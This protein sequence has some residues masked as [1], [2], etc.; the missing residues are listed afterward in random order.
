MPNR[1]LVILIIASAL[2]M[3]NL[4]STVLTT[5]L[6]AIA[7]DFGEDPIRLK[8]ALTSYLIGLAVFIPASGWLA[9]RFGARNV[10]STA[11]LVFIT[12]SILC[13]L[14]QSIGHIVVARVIQ[15]LG[16]A[17]MVPVGRLVVLR[18]VP[19]SEMVDAMAW[20]AIPAL[21]GPVL[22]PPLG[23]F[24][25][26]YFSWQWIFWINVP[27]G[28]V[29]LVLARI[30]VP[31]IREEARPRFDIVGFL[32]SGLGLSAIVSGSTTMG[33]DVIPLPW[34]AA[35]LAVG[36]ILIAAYVRHSRRVAAPILDLSLFAVP[37]YRAAVLGGMLFRIGIG[38]SPFLLPL[39]LQIGFGLTPFQS[40]MITF[41][42]ALGAIGMKLCASRLVRHFGFR[43]ILVLNAL[44][45][46]AFVAV[47]AAFS[48]ATPFALIVAILLVGGFFRS[49]QFTSINGLAFSDLESPRMSG[50]TSLTSV[51]QQ[52]S[53]SLGISVAAIVLH[54][55]TAG[56][57]A[58]SFEV[59]DFAPAFLVVGAAAALSAFVFAALPA[60]AGGQVSGHRACGQG[61]VSVARER[62]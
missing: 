40:G 49:L 16:G 30:Y 21:T 36:A 5:A 10:F 59:A 38:A 27:I 9:D 31:D 43:R 11:I 13:A 23:G 20:L 62:P 32:L 39:M 54:T 51:M 45:C 14:S 60:A 58:S 50:G 26:T 57:P 52:F 55:T 12:G 15:A 7:A 19:K 22:G 33:L 35:L 3:E 47:P 6:P 4:D 1:R 28:C 8:L 34:V 44:L 42:G 24:I 18:S 48:E 37:T 17:M 2:F 25:T 61:A 29:G 56:E 53:L 46:A 41:A